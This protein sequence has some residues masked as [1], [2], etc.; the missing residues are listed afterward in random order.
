MQNT[1]NMLEQMLEKEARQF[2]GQNGEKAEPKTS[3]ITVLDLEFL[4]DRNAHAGYKIC[5]GTTAC[6]DIRWPFHQV[7]AA[8]WMTAHFS[9][10]SDVPEITGPTVLLLET[11]SERDLL[12]NL[13][14]ALHRS[15]SSI[16]VTW[17]GEARD[18]AVLRHR[19]AVHD[20]IL[21]MQL[22]PSSPHA[23]Q[24]LDLCRD[25][26]VQATPVHLSEY[27]AASSIPSKPIPSKQIGLLAEQGEWG[28]VRE[29]VAADVL[30]TTI[31]ALRH[32]A[33]RELISCDRAK[34]VTAVAEA[35][36]ETIPYSRFVNR[37]LVPWASGQ[38]TKVRGQKVSLA[39]A[40]LN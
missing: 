1:L 11:M 6:D 19:A 29:Q 39:E 23:P 18:L 16:L 4:W 31:I 2:E 27:A 17:G 34:S 3:S 24:R 5:E 14:A 25:V 7:A 28:K 12:E 40:A 36:S 30:T 32:L 13:F 38:A 37:D 26:C 9:S 33:A 20:L 22:R 8:C 15:P 21:P 35:A 10:T